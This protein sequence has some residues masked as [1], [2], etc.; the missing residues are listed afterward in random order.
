MATSS[1]YKATSPDEN[2][3]NRFDSSDSE[4]V[5][6]SGDESGLSENIE[7]NG[8]GVEIDSYEE[9]QKKEQEA[10]K[11]L[12]DEYRKVKSIISLP[13]LLNLLSEAMDKLVIPT[14]TDI[15]NS[16]SNG[17]PFFVDGDMLL[18]HAM[19]DENWS[20]RFGGQMLHLIYLCERRM[21]IFVNKGGTFQIRHEHPDP[22]R[23]ERGNLNC[24]NDEFV[25]HGRDKTQD[26]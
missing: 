10:V 16:V 20:S 2:E 12:E 25:V 23:E 26:P 17:T 15:S 3:E 1:D 21:Q 7:A 4:D 22:G 13:K 18:V 6:E 24:F 5:G 9:E 8:G 14:Y 19:A 11:E